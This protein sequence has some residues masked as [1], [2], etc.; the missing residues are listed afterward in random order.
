M[1]QEGALAASLFTGF[2][3]ADITQAGL[4]AVVVT[5]G[6][7][8]RAEALRDELLDSAWRQRESFV[9][10][11]EPLADSVS[12]AKSL[13]E[14]GEA[15]PVIILDHYDNTA[16]G[17]TMDTTEVLAE[18]L[19]QG[20]SDVAV[21]GIY[22]PGAV[23]EIRAAGVAKKVSLS[24]G[25]KMKMP[26]IFRQ[27]RPLH[28]EG[29]VR[30]IS[31]GEYR[32]TGPMGRGL[33]MNMGTTAVLDTGKVQIVVISRHVE[34]NDPGCFT[35]VGIVP[36]QKRFLMLK[37]RVHYRAGFRGMARA[38]VECA[39]CG[40]CTSD[41]GELIFKNVRRPIFPLDPD[42]F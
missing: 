1:E 7:G 3:H 13:G 11:L 2:P 18:V 35:S 19:G 37:S 32:V 15:G 8:T 24:L 17:G 4:S 36:E 28:V 31:N 41:Y 6:D 20:L 12:R 42:A 21:F 5:D 25:G 38:V 33:L 16:S 29:T 39:G 23:A 30:L 14:S 26:A 40:V 10:R 9:Y 34:P 22:D 27:S